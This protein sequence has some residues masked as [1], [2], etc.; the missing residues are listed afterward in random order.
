MRLSHP[1]ALLLLVLLPVIAALA[2]PAAGRARRQETISLG[3]RLVL[4]MCLILALAGLEVVRAGNDLE[5]VFLLD[6]SDSMPAESRAAAAE[7]VRQ[8]LAGMGPDDRAAVV[9]F[10]GDALVERGMSSGP[11]WGP[12]ASVPDR[13]QTDLEAAIQLAGALYHPQAAKRMVILSDGAA[14]R[15]DTAG[16]LRLASASGVELLA[17]SSDNRPRP[18]VSVREVRTPSSVRQGDSF[19]LAITVQAT[20]ATPADLIVYSEGEVVYAAR[21]QIAAGLQTLNLPLTAAARGLGLYEV[22]IVAAADTYYQNNRQAAFVDV[23]GPP[24]VLVVAPPEGE[25]LGFGREARPDEAAALVA[26][27]QSAGYIVEAARPIELPSGSLPEL[28]D[29]GAIVLIDVPA[30]SLVPRQIELLRAYVREFGGG[31]VTVGGPTSYGVGGYFRTPLEEM[32]PVE[33]QIRGE[34]RRPSL[35]LVFI[36][37]RSGSMAEVSGGAVKLELAKEAVI[38]SVE[39]LFPGDRLG[40]VAFDDV[41]HWVVELA[42]LEDPRPVIHEIGTLRPGGGTDI[43]AGLQAVAEVLPDDPSLVRHM[44]LLTD[45][46]ADPTG[47]SDLVTRL[48]DEQGIT[49]TTVGV[50]SDA[51]PYLR[52][53]AALGGGRYHFAAEPASIPMIFTEETAL[54]SRSYIVEETFQPQQVNP[55]PILQGV[56]QVPRL[57]GYVA[58]SPKIAARTLLVSEQGDP[59]LAEWQYGLG[60]TVAFTSDATGRW[61][62]DWVNW[63]GFAPFWS[64]AVR[65]TVG[66]PETSS[67]QARVARGDDEARLVV[68]ARGGGGAPGRLNGYRVEARVIGPAGETQ[69]L[70]LPQV[71]P[72]RYA[73]DFDLGVPGAYLIR[74]T[75]EPG[76]GVAGSPVAT[77][78]GWVESYSAEYAQPI[79]EMPGLTPLVEAQ[80]GRPAPA[81]PAEVFAHTLAAPVAAR[82]VGPWLLAFAA[83]LLPFDIAFRRLVLSGADLHKAWN[84]LSGGRRDAKVIMAAPRRSERVD[85]LLSA[86]QRAHARRPPS[87]SVEPGRPE[88]GTP[89][90]PEGAH[91]SDRPATRHH[92]PSAGT[93]ADLLASKTRRASR[94][95]KAGRA[96]NRNESGNREE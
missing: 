48:Q 15:G 3:L 26:A 42:E 25:P 12:I 51:A 5:A 18:E 53:L 22:Q 36:I 46:G 90:A 70:V 66:Q 20:D 91:R 83:L 77:T 38:R 61:A 79:S 73:E 7:Y 59:I 57:H 93:V 32:S 65:S 71:A 92:A 33:M 96:D 8:A 55:S 2:W 11:D 81:N 19:D 45:G 86:K 76:P 34:E 27:L 88:Q 54:I 40:V 50:G 52:D 13:S 75:G 69:S 68:E 84:K 24:R 6:V 72:G 1:L 4:M 35:A 16:A 31:L 63:A 67:L 21:H 29:Y 44:I 47:I 58:T 39:M 23:L 17:L 87:G 80:G 60:R 89:V 78:V 74:I 85:A 82:P 95:G 30:R 49:L 28:A 64:Q 41:A 94:Q 14:T 56:G 9:V 62:R 43:L 10:G 37:D